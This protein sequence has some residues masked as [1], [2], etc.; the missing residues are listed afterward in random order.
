MG[1]GPAF[2]RALDGAEEHQDQAQREGDLAPQVQ[3]AVREDAGFGGHLQ[4]ERQVMTAS[5]ATTP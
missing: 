3:P 4:G 1:G 2:L 5:P